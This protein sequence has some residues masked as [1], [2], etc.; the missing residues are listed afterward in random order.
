MAGHDTKYGVL[1]G[2]GDHLWSSDR[3]TTYGVLTGQADNLWS[4]DR[5]RQTTRI[6]DR[7]SENMK[8]SDS[9]REKRKEL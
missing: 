2:K 4:S 6:F 8:S 3:T 1:T 9:R 5:T 7:T